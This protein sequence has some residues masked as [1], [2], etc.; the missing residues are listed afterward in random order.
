MFSLSL[1]LTR[2]QIALD[3]LRNIAY[4]NIKLSTRSK[5]IVDELFSTFS[6]EY[7]LPFSRI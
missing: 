4:Q 3:L 7:V 1:Y 5:N 2:A 6:A